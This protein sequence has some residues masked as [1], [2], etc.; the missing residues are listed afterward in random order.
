[1]VNQKFT[2]VQ[3]FKLKL[4][5]CQMSPHV[6]VGQMGV[7]QV[8]VGQMGVGKPSVGQMGDGQVSRIR[9]RDMFSER[10]VHF[11]KKV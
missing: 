1:M 11:V 8:G 5:V 2:L 6:L 3:T 9:K 7:G 4:S 10:G